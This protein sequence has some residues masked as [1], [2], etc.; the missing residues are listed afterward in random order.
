[1]AEAG[2]LNINEVLRALRG[3]RLQRPS[4]FSLER[5]RSSLILLS[6]GQA[7]EYLI[8]RVDVSEAYW[9]NVTQPV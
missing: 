6:A 4:G 3:N 2:L 8:C 5:V 1:M 9:A 7:Y